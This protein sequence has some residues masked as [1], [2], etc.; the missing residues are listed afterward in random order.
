MDLA[1]IVTGLKVAFLGFGLKALSAIAIWVVGRWLI[2]VVSSLLRRALNARHID[3]TITTYVINTLVVALNIFLAMAI[4]SRF[5][6]ETTSFAALLAGAGL[7]IGTAWAGMLANFAAG[8]F[9]V[10]LRPFKVGDFVNAAGVTGTVREIGIFVTAIDTPDNV[11]TYVGNNKVFSGDIL[12]FHTNPYRRV[13]L[14]AQLAGGADH[15]RAIAALKEAVKTRVPSVLGD[16]GPDVEI[17]EFNEFGPVLCV[18][19]YCN[20]DY[21]WQ[22]YF[23]TNRVIAEVLADFPAPAR[24]VAIRS[25]APVTLAPTAPAGGADGDPPRQMQ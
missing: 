24:P 3:H 21:Y 7:A 16:P 10:I 5:G 13:D 11:R 4:L 18:R 8:A 20:N 6:V 22:V 1:P 15:A 19:P 17:L 23:D 14:K 25:I 9:M 12:N 2:N